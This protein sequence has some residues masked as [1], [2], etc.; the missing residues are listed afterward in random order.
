MTV[1]ALD[2]HHHDI[3][4]C[5]VL[6]ILDTNPAA[7]TYTQILD[8]LPVAQVANDQRY[9]QLWDVHPISRHVAFVSRRRGGSKKLPSQI[10]D[11]SLEV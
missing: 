4:N 5:A 1:K 10:R 7:E 2:A 9:H 6:R 8:G 3:L 11:R